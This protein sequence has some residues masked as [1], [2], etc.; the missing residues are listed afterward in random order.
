MKSTLDTIAF[1]KNVRETLD[2]MSDEDAGALMKALFAHDDGEE[3]DLSGKSAVVRVGYLLIAEATDRLTA[4]R[5]S[6]VRKPTANEPQTNRKQ[7]ANA[8][9][10]AAHNHSLNLNHPSVEGIIGRNPKIQKAY[11]FS[12][13]RPDVNYDEVAKQNYWRDAE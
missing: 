7:T 12:T 1:F 9:Q 11:G 6:K 4:K 5:M 3:P 2:S 8:P 13:E 10:N